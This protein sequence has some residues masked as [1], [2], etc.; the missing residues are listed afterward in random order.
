MTFDVASCRKSADMVWELWVLLPTLHTIISST[1][2]TISRVG[3]GSEWPYLLVCMPIVP[4]LSL[5]PT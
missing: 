3:G 1:D 4:A 5:T 2:S